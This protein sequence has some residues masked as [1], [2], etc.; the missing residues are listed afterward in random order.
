MNQFELNEKVWVE[1]RVK[2]RHDNFTLIE[3]SGSS[4]LI[5]N[6]DLYMENI[7]SGEIVTS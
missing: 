4:L 5:S 6:N 1:A 3:I 2:E 7:I